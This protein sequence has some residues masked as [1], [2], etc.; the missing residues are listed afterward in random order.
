MFNKNKRATKVLAKFNKSKRNYNEFVRDFYLEN[1]KAYISVKVKD[2]HEIISKFSIK[3]YEWL[4]DEFANYIQEN[5]YYIP[6]TYDI[7]LEICGKFK[8]EEKVII[9]RT[10][11]TYFGVKLGDAQI[12]L[13]INRKKTL[14]LLLFGF[15]SLI[16]FLF[17]TLYIVNFKFIEPFS[18]L[19]WFLL[20]EVL[21]T[22]FLER[23]GLKDKKLEAAQ[24]ANMTIIFN[25]K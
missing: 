1:N 21:D 19:L 25:E 15:I 10:I 24:L 9:T 5:A 11:K 18:I 23:K 6:I 22:F 2:Y 20:W 8:K 3:D 17:L 12:D 4:S 7:I 13:N 16:V 14:T